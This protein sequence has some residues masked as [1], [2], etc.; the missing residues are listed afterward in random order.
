MSENPGQIDVVRAARDGHQFHE[1]WAARICLELL[2]PETTLRAVAIEGFS[3]EEA[4]DVSKAAHEIADLTR[5]YGGTRIVS[6]TRI[7][8]MQF[9]YSVASANEP[10]RAAEM[11]KTLCKFAVADKDIEAVRSGE[12]DLATFTLITNRPIDHDTIAALQALRCGTMT[13]GRVKRHLHQL[14]DAIRLEGKALQA[15]ARRLSFVGTGDAL[16]ATEHSNL[17]VLASWS[18]ATDNLSDARLSNLRQLVRKRAGEHGQYD[19]VIGRVDVLGALGVAYE[20]DLY[21][22]EAAFPAIET[23]I[24][25]PVL[26]DLITALFAD[27]RAL[28]VH[29][30]GGLGKTVLMQALA[31]ELGDQHCVLLFDGF[32]AGRWREPSDGRHLPR[33]SLPHLANLLAANGLCDIQLPANHLEDNIGALRDRLGAS[34]RALRA[35]SPDAHVVLIL[36]AIDHCGMQA[37]RTGTQ[38]FA[39]ILL[40]SLN[41]A[42]LD[43]VRVVAS[44]RSHRRHH[45]QGDARCREFEVPPFTR[46]EAELLIRGRFPTASEND[47]T[48]LQRRSAGNPR[49]LD[50]LLRRGEPFDLERP[51]GEGQTLDGLLS[52]QI[53][54]AQEQA[55]ARG[56]TQAEARGLLAGMAMLPPPVPIEELAA[57]L[58]LDAMDVHSFVAD[59][60]PLI[61]ATPTGLIFRDEPTETLIVKMIRADIVARR[62]LVKRLLARQDCSIY[63]ARALPGILVEDGEIDTLVTLAFDPLSTPDLSRVAHR[64]VRLARLEAA[65]AACAR[66]DRTDDLTRITLEA[67]RIASA[68]ERSDAFLRAHPDLVALSEDPEAIRRFRDDRSGWQ[69]IRHS[70]LAV[71]DAF[72]GDLHSASLESDRAITWLN[73]MLRE[74]RE[75]KTERHID[76]AKLEA[77]AI[78]VQL[79]LGKAIR[80]DRWLSGLNDIH[81][82][83]IATEMLAFVGRLAKAKNASAPAG[84]VTAAIENCRTRSPVVIASIIEQI[85]VT[86]DTRRRLLKRLATLKPDPVEPSDPFDYRREDR[87]SDASLTAAGQAVGIGL[88]REAQAIAS[89]APAPKVRTY[90][91]SD[92]WAMSGGAVLRH[93]KRAA[94]AAAAR[95]RP[96]AITDILPEEMRALVPI[97]IRRR[98]PAAFERYLR[99]VVAKAQNGRAKRRKKLLSSDEARRWESLLSHRLTPLTSL[100]DDVARI[101]AAD[102]PGPAIASTLERAKNAI[103]SASNYPYRDQDRFLRHLCLDVLLWAAQCR[104]PLDYASG[105]GLAA[106]L[107]QSGSQL[108]SDWLGYTALLARAPE[109]QAAALRLARQAERVIAADTNISE[110]IQSYGKLA[111]ALLPI[112]PDEARPYFRIGLELAD[113]VGSD[114]QERIGD[115]ITFAAQYSGK[116][117]P[118]A[119]VHQFVRLCELN[120]PDEAEALDWRSFAKA[121]AAI[122]S[123][124]G[125]APIARLSDRDKI[126][127]GWTLA[128]ML[129]A[130]VERDRL[131][132]TLAA[133][134]FGL[135]PFEA[136]WNWFLP[137]AARPI[138]AGLP[139]HLR[140]VFADMIVIDLDRED[141]AQPHRETVNGLTSLFQDELSEQAAAR[142]RIERL[143]ADRIRGASAETAPTAR[144][145]PIAPDALRKASAITTDELRAAIEQRAAEFEGNRPT[146][147]FV[148]SG[149]VAD[150][151]EPGPRTALLSAV[152]E[153]LQLSFGDKL[154]FLEEAQE[155]WA[156]QSRALDG[157]LEDAALSIASRHLE[158]VVRSGDSWR[159]PLSGVARLAGGAR[160]SL[161]TAVL[162]AT[163]GQNLEVSSDFWMACAIEL[164]RTA[165]ASAIG[166][167]LG[168][169]AE[170]STQSLPDTI[171]DG[172]W[173]CTFTP[174]E[175]E[176][177]IVAELLWMRLGAPDAASRWRA[178][179]T[180]RRLVALGETRFLDALVARIDRTG[181]RAFQDQS[182]PFFHLHARLWLLIAIARLASDAPAT[183]LPHR[184]TLEAIA[185]SESF[186]HVLCRHF[187]ILALRAI[188]LC[189][190]IPEPDTYLAWLET[191]NVP[192]K[193]RI[194]RTGH[195]PGFYDKRP[196]DLPEHASPFRFD[197][198]FDKYQIDAM[199]RLFGLPKWDI[200]DTATNWVRRYDAEVKTMWD[201]PRPRWWSEEGRSYSSTSC[202]ELDR[203]GGYLAWHALMLT[204]GQFAAEK[205]IISD[206]WQEEPWENW[207]A[208]VTLSRSDGLWVADVTDMFPLED[209]RPVM[210]H[211][212]GAS[213]T[214]WVPSHPLDL[215]PL[216]GFDDSLDL[217][218][219]FLVSGSWESIDGL[220]VTIGS[221]LVECDMA[222]TVAHAVYSGD[223]FFAY[224]P[225]DGDDGFDRREDREK[226][227]L[228]RWLT[229]NEHAYTKLDGHDPYGF[230]TALHRSRPSAQTI[231]KMSL[232]QADPLERLW[233]DSAERWAFRAQAW[234]TRRGHGRHATERGGTRLAVNWDALKSLLEAEQQA[235]LV[236]IKVRHYIEKDPKGDHFRHQMLALIVRPDQPLETLYAVS[237]P[238]R[239]AIA[240]RGHDERDEFADRLAAIKA[241]GCPR[242]QAWPRGRARRKK[243]PNERALSDAADQ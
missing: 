134:L 127:L 60:F 38:S 208:E 205:P 181:A 20:R 4:G 182:L 66:G 92:P 59:L 63:A 154:S 79:L 131:R 91:I 51:G 230:N 7:D 119:A 17:E 183:V 229:S 74:Y 179:H 90:E 46:Q 157:R 129:K 226:Q 222:R 58:G 210:P 12:P 80:V 160:E 147:G 124:G 185:T 71:L 47:I 86:P 166:E 218:S 19:N 21:P 137:E 94:I 149:F 236:L 67:S 49:L 45:A 220:N 99:G 155:R 112:S 11:A 175:E 115:F 110:Q 224:L 25:R 26:Q 237:K 186:P 174:P 146:D 225:I 65:A 148:L 168:R 130:L 190:S 39:Q 197:Y 180:I 105:E 214:A 158:A 102:R 35:F 104:E 108:V 198:D 113:A 204:A 75:G 87:L 141:A 41:V 24:A 62:D 122:G 241:V 84:K 163:P 42:P 221:Q 126:G 209:A 167:A 32:G 30:A 6:A 93:I 194:P 34:V 203:Y 36:D 171:G 235:L 164:A 64:A 106:F 240:N 55:I 40:Q 151:T 118:T 28:L 48:V 82:F 18:G 125:L 223:P 243:S 138:M 44:C 173:M 216:A 100:V 33:K 109:T 206:S 3:H 143:H 22:V 68:T 89:H 85:E 199:G 170:H 150:V 83:N 14:S 73:W 78:F 103:T 101:L 69:G 212:P 195:R 77:E 233:I 72:S 213:E 177:A 56:A 162:K 43:G 88:V 165:S 81:A 116:P 211:V 161:V 207:L 231:E 135:A 200:Q 192:A 121:M 76:L 139:G 9:K 114:D 144:P 29:A 61:E 234:G 156:G 54:A 120:F 159:S 117:L 219:S 107:E 2:P 232:Q 133:G 16:D 169:Y 140:E 172:P 8:V 10:M 202:P 228:T 196:D 132:P 13:E 52:E 188:A 176:D 70:A 97:S 23:P 98:G 50:N 53:S 201:C 111:R 193:P 184:S 31:R 145:K 136:T 15:F 128:P 189:G 57:A 215:L 95:R 123:A 227:L 153:D 191:L 5:Y 142:T 187:A 1:A 178:A 37:E 152:T 217:P 242:R 238:V 239:A 96:T 27:P